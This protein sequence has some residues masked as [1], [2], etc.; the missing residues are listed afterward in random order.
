MV[1]DEVS[2]MALAEDRFLVSSKDL[3]Y[4]IFESRGSKQSGDM[5]A[6]GQPGVLG[7]QA[8]SQ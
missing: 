2:L 4:N 3:A 1:P 5:A 8:V 6:L 7:V